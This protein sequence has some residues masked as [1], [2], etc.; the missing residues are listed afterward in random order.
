MK[1]DALI[2]G[3]RRSLAAGRTVPRQSFENATDGNVKRPSDLVEHGGTHAV[4]GVL[5]LLQLFKS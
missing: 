1:V 5:V 4:L 2:D 3:Q